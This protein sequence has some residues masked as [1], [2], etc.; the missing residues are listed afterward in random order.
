M[1]GE[2]LE[3]KKDLV[4]IN[5]EVLE[6]PYAYFDPNERTSRQDQGLTDFAPTSRYGPVVVPKGK[7]FNN[8]SI[9]DSRHLHHPRLFNCSVNGK[10]KKKGFNCVS[11]SS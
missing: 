11:I 8:I 4:F 3:I 2:K 6:E 9:N 1:P 7:L 10:Y 5:G